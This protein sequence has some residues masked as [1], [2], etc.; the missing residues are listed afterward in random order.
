MGFGSGA[1]KRASRGGSVLLADAL[2]ELLAPL[3]YL[4]LLTELLDALGGLLD[5]PERALDLAEFLLHR[6]LL[7]VLL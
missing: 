7:G 2:A 3:A 6:G 1:K 5:V 4:A